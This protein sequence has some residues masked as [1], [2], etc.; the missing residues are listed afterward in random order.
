MAEGSIEQIKWVP[1]AALCWTSGAVAEVALSSCS[2][3]GCWWH[4]C[5]RALL[6]QACSCHVA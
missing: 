2:H 4:V 5:M 3:E 6:L 1:A